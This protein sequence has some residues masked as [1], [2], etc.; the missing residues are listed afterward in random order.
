MGGVLILAVFQEDRAQVKF[1]IAKDEEAKR[2]FSTDSSAVKQNSS[3]LS[4]LL[5]EKFL[6]LE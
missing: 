1:N 5:N 6:P 3:Q 2:D 4:L